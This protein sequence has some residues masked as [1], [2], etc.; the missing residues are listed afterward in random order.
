MMYLSLK[1]IKVR[2]A[3]MFVR[4]C[5]LPDVARNIFIVLNTLQNHFRNNTEKRWTIFDLSNKLA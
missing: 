5:L 3:K 1:N 4:R 2:H